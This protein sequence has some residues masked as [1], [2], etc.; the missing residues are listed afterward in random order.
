MMP[1]SVKR[2]SDYIMRYNNETDHA[3]DFGLI[4]SKIIVIGGQMTKRTN[5]AA[6]PPGTR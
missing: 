5:D 3:C 2:F 6:E 1:K 4:R